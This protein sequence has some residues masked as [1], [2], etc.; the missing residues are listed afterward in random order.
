MQRGTRGWQWGQGA[1][2]LALAVGV[3]IAGQA[4]ASRPGLD[5]DRSL[6][7]QDSPPDWRINSALD[8]EFHIYTTGSPKAP[9]RR[10]GSIGHI[11]WVLA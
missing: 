9:W 5:E 3:A 8:G 10:F 11:S 1:A 4:S 7:P 2:L 6:P